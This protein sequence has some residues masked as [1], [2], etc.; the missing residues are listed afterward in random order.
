MLGVRRDPFCS[1]VSSEPVLP[2]DV[3]Y[4]ESYETSPN[5]FSVDLRAGNSNYPIVAILISPSFLLICTTL[6]GCIANMS[7]MTD[8]E[9][10]QAVMAPIQDPALLM[11]SQ[12]RPL[13]EDECHFLG[14]IIDATMEHHIASDPTYAE[15][16][17]RAALQRPERADLY[18]ASLEDSDI[19]DDEDEDEGYA[20]GD[21]SPPAPPPPPPVAAPP[22]RRSPSPPLNWT[23]NGRIAKPIRKIPI[24]AEPYRPPP[25]RSKPYR[26][27][28]A[29]LD[30]RQKNQVL[31]TFRNAPRQLRFDVFAGIFG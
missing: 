20:S 3:T 24:K 11:Q 31:L 26:Y 25:T 21:Q 15:M 4:D 19:E 22:A 28:E 23:K 7:S 9:L 17:R 5:G 13:S 10:L 12:K 27:Y 18:W 30:Y 16:K 14:K 29:S 1:H 6:H 8:W 2:D